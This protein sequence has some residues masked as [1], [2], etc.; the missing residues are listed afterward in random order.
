MT[1]GSFYSLAGREFERETIPLLKDQGLGLLVW[2]PLAGGFLAG[3]RGSP[4]GEERRFKK[5]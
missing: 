2:S 3:N 5:E 1:F 4:S